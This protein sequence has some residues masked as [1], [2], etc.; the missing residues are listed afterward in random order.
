LNVDYELQPFVA[1]CFN[2]PLD[3]T[4]YKFAP[5]NRCDHFNLKLSLELDVLISNHFPELRSNLC[6]FS[7]LDLIGLKELI[8]LL[9]QAVQNKQCNPQTYEIITNVTDGLLQNYKY[10]ELTPQQNK[11]LTE[12]GHIPMVLGQ[13][14]FSLSKFYELLKN[15]SDP[16]EFDTVKQRTKEIALIVGAFEYCLQ[17]LSK[18]DFLEQENLR[19][20]G[21]R[22]VCPFCLK[23][24]KSIDGSSIVKPHIDR[25]RMFND[26]ILDQ[27]LK[28]LNQSS[29]CN[30][31]GQLSVEVDVGFIKTAIIKHH[32]TL[33]MLDRVLDHTN[34]RHRIRSA[35][36]AKKYVQARHDRLIRY[37]HYY[38][39]EQ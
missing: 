32:S 10:L 4:G 25:L 15:V 19:V 28:T 18:D 31:T 8:F 12:A 30:G 6:L 13:D 23:E 36:S 14:F 34:L 11:L 38:H 7:G 29:H 33:L 3:Y 20:P 27:V 26:S 22:T 9:N 35:K 1:K 39:D 2:T 17:M 24:L 16:K 5:E 21:G 37:Y